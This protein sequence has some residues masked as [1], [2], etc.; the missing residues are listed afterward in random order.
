[1]TDWKPEANNAMHTA[2]SGDLPE[3]RRKKTAPRWFAHLWLFFLVVFL[4]GFSASI[5]SGKTCDLLATDFRG[6]YAAG[7][8]AREA[9][10]AAVYDPEL[11]AESQATLYLGCPDGTARPPLM[12]VMVPYLPIFVLLFLPLPALDFTA[13]YIA[14]SLVNLVIFILYLYRFSN[15]LHIRLDSLRLFQWAL[16]FALLANLTLGQIN[17]LLVIIL[18]EFVLAFKRDK[19]LWGG[20]WLAGLLLKPNLLILLLPGLLISWRWKASLGFGVSA[21]LLLGASLLLAGTDGLQAW[22]EVVCS[23][24]ESSF[25]SVPN[26]MNARALAYHMGQILPAWLAWLAAAAVTVITALFVLAR[27]IASNQ[28]DNLLWLMLATLAGTFVVAWHS[29]LYLW[30]VLIPFLFV[31]D[32]EGQLPIIYLAFW[33]FGPAVVY[34]L[35]YFFNPALAHPV[36]GMAMLLANLV[37][38]V[39]STRR[40]KCDP[41]E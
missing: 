16:C 27:W 6:Y 39:H 22:L 38:V 4:I 37:L 17:A 21:A 13:S 9:G 36:L 24:A 34:G 35:V 32:S 7:L 3:R 19:A 41:N 18:G 31:L 33:A 10:L 23:F 12:Q 5:A 29:N 14:W 2:M 11:Q 8:I 20:A 26:M 25:N 30:M 1:M 28:R 15:A 40:L